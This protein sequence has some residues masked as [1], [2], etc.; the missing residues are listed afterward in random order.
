MKPWTRSATVAVSIAGALALTACT[1][2]SGPEPEPSLG[3]VPT[4]RGVAD[5]VLPLDAYRFTNKDYVTKVRA[6]ARLTADC[7]RRFGVTYPADT[8]TIVVGVNVPNFDRVN[9]RRYGLIDLGSAAERGYRLPAQ[10]GGDE[11]QRDEARRDSGGDLPQHTLFIL[12]GKRQAGFADAATMPTDTNGKRL[13]DD[14]CAGEAERELAGG[15]RVGDVGLVDTLA[16]ETFDRSEND[17]RVRTALAAWSACMKERGYRF[18]T[19]WEPN[20]RNWPTSVGSEEIA[21]AKADVGCKLQTNVVGIWLAVEAAY[22]RRTI[23]K[24]PQQLAEL[25]KYLHEAA[26]NAA[27]IMGGS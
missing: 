9:E 22:Q 24:H 8:G 11:T 19:I 14:G 16:N 25:Q 26:R 7:A 23:D 12:R 18:S 15:T 21:T 5:L 13:P 2:G 10:P 6:Q 27:R 20:D 3:A 1:S 17:S 4:V